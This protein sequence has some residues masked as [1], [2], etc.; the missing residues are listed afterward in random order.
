MQAAENTPRIDLDRII[1]SD[2]EPL[3]T[4]DGK[5]AVVDGDTVDVLDEQGNPTERLRIS[6]IDAAEK[7]MATGR[8]N[9]HQLYR[10]LNQGGVTFE[11][12]G[13]DDYGRTVARLSSPAGDTAADMARAGARSPGYQREYDAEAREFERQ[14]REGTLPEETQRALAAN[15][16]F[17]ADPTKARKPKHSEFTKGVVSGINTMQGTLYGAAALAGDALGSE[18]LRAKGL[19]GYQRNAEEAAEDAPRVGS[20]KD[21]HGVGDAIDFAM[22]QLGAASPSLATSVGSGAIGAAVAR[23]VVKKGIDREIAKGV[24]K[25]AKE[26]SKELLTAGK[27]GATVGAAATSSVQGAGGIEGELAEHGISAPG[28]AAVGGAITGALD[29]LPVLKLI[30]D[31]F[32]GVDRALAKSFVRGFAEATGKQA[33]L[34]GTTEGAQEI[35]AL[36][37]RALHDPAFEWSDPSVRQRIIDSAAGGAIVGGVTGVPG[38]VKQGLTAKAGNAPGP[39]SGAKVETHDYDDESDVEGSASQVRGNEEDFLAADGVR[40]RTGEDAELEALGAHEALSLIPEDEES[41]PMVYDSREAGRVPKNEF[42][43]SRL[44]DAIVSVSGGKD[45]FGNKQKGNWKPETTVLFREEGKGTPRKASSIELVRMGMDMDYEG[46]ELPLGQRIVRGITNA[47]YELEEATE[48][49]LEFIQDSLTDNTVV[50]D[51]GKNRYTWGMI[52]K[53]AKK[54]TTEKVREVTHGADWKREAELNRDAGVTAP[55]DGRMADKPNYFSFADKNAEGILES[56]DSLRESMDRGKRIS[57]QEYSFYSKF[58]KIRDQL[59][60]VAELV[61]KQRDLDRDRDEWSG[62]KRKLNPA[63]RK[64]EARL[65]AKLVDLNKRIEEAESPDLRKDLAGKRK[66]VLAELEASYTRYTQTEAAFARR[67]K[68]INEAYGDRVA[69]IERA[70]N[71]RESEQTKVERGEGYDPV[72]G[73]LPTDAQQAGA[74]SLSRVPRARVTQ[75]TLRQKYNRAHR[76]EVHANIGGDQQRAESVLNLVAE[77]AGI[78]GIEN[79]I[80]VTDS[81]GSERT[82]NQVPEQLGRAV[83]KAREQDPT[84][85][86]MFHQDKIA[87]YLSSRLNDRS[88]VS[89]VAVVAHELGHAVSRI[90]FE[91]AGK[92]LQDRLRKAYEESGSKKD[93]EEWM[94]DQFVAWASRRSAPKNVVESFFKRVAAKLRE[95]WEL[96]TNKYKLDETYAEFMD[97]VAQYARRD[98]QPLVNPLARHFQSMGVAGSG[99]WTGLPTNDNFTPVEVGKKVADAV[100]PKLARWEKGVAFAKF[101]G[102]TLAEIHNTFTAMVDSRLRRM[103]YPSLVALARKFHRRAG[104]GGTEETFPRALRGARARFGER[105]RTVLK[106]VTQEEL[107]QLGKDLLRADGKFA[108]RT[109]GKEMRHLFDELYAYMADAGLPIDKLENYYPIVYSN[110]KLAAGKDEFIALATKVFKRTKRQSR[111]EDDE[112]FSARAAKAAEELYESMLDE[113]APAYYQNGLGQVDPSSRNTPNPNVGHVKSRELWHAMNE[114]ERKVL[115]QFMEDDL[116]VVTERYIA[117]ATKLAEYN[118]L[119]G[120]GAE[121]NPNTGKWVW[122]PN[123]RLEDLLE[124][125][126]NAG[127]TA[128]Q[129]REVWKILDANFG[130]VGLDVSPNVRKFSSWVMLYQNFRVLTYTLFSSLVDLAGPAMRTGDVKQAFTSMVKAVRE[131]AKSDSD[132]ANMARTYGSISDV[133]N[134]HVL[135]EHLDNY[136]VDPRVR[137]YNEKFFRYTGVQWWTNFTRKLALAVGKDYMEEA[138]TKGGAEATRKL[139]ELGLTAKDVSTWIAAGRP[140]YGRKGVTQESRTAG[141]SK[142]GAADLDAAEKVAKALRRFG[143]EAILRPTAAMRPAWASDPK[144]MLVWHLKSFMYSFQATFLNRIWHELNRPGVSPRQQ[145]AYVLPIIALFPLAALGLELR[146]LFQYG[147]KQS[148]YDRMDADEYLFELAKRTG[149]FGLSQMAIDFNEAEDRDRI[150][151]IAVAGPTLSQIEELVSTPAG[152]SIPRSL[153]VLSA[154]PWLR[155]EVKELFGA[156]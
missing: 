89:T 52:Q 104:E 87:I 47:F 74:S 32:P 141:Y 63:K 43:R 83:R 150:G 29:A 154:L 37:A 64:Q 66:E 119:F 105:I 100:A 121:K 110:E 90:F 19:A 2:N 46:R 61:R 114:E 7:S 30:D 36:T 6:G 142:M 76:A 107:D 58:S 139:A 95:M 79:E 68:E 54:A 12:E 93:F 92:P 117:A 1:H 33:L 67:Q 59:E 124:L 147:T 44:R 118:R 123:Q 45:R 126:V 135:S 15:R 78:A 23:K 98:T 21:V 85:R 40:F 111:R 60:R 130:K 101:T 115:R 108:N 122:N 53:A 18:E 144:W 133:F 9:K 84:G 113:T 55:S 20:L 128:P 80:F 5:Y 156:E 26:M 13:H 65:K 132:L 106:G 149:V 153:P 17:S 71:I 41:G 97:G 137:E 151:L 140:V 75:K 31:L 16:P 10:R 112:N 146:E 62:K 155:N 49:K 77:L 125:A 72:A 96:L 3:R 138:A 131:A 70:Q 120:S 39:V 143:D 56:L 4:N 116:R 35:V 145:L 69:E 11:R 134:D 24:E 94:A 99:Y 50:Y 8:L 22:G 14:Y 91:K 81:E 27:V 109:L 73:N 103:G 148:P 136:Y 25:T 86:V 38:G 48:G 88:P 57:K 102:N 129:M 51:D 82:A 42:L 152:Q 34:E 28:T 127:A